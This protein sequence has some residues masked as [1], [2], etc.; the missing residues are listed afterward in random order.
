M[1]AVVSAAHT[2]GP[3]GVFSYRPWSV[4]GDAGGVQ[5]ASCRWIDD[6][7]QFAHECAPDEAAQANARLIVA[8]PDLLAEL[9]HLVR[10]LEPLEESGALNV[11]GLASLNGARLAIAKA[12]GEA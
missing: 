3:W 7:G 8:A 5:V 1:V 12:R 6:T 9:A 10:L 2:P 4:F 11:P